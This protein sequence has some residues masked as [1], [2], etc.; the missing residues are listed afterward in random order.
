MFPREIPRPLPNRED[1]MTEDILDDTTKPEGVSRDSYDKRIHE[2]LRFLK[3]KSELFLSKEALKTYSPKFLKILENI[4]KH[5][6][7]HLIYSQFRT[8]EG[9]G[10]LKLILEYAG[11]VEFKI[12]KG[13]A[14]WRITHPKKLGKPAFVLYTGTESSEQKEIIRN[15]FN[16][17]WGKV[18]EN[19]VEQISNIAENNNNGEIIRVF[20]LTAAGA[21]GISLK[22]VRYVHITEP[23]WHPVRI[24]QVIGRAR[25]ICSHHS[26]PEEERFVTVFLYLMTFSEEM[27]KGD[28]LSIELRLHDTSRLD[29][30]TPLTSDE[31][32]YEISNIKKSINEQLLTAVKESSMDCLLYARIDG[33]EKLAC[34]TMGGATPNRFTY[35]PSISE[36]DDDK[37]ADLNLLKIKWKAKL[38]KIKSKGYAYRINDTDPDN[39]RH[40]LYDLESYKA[41]TAVLKGF[42]IMG[43]NN[44]PKKVKWL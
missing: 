5:E 24:E 30:T 28:K 17:D 31:A 13:R 40:E 11:F 10:I 16:S 3:K 41:G 29:K 27:I 4:E 21:E 18:P 14:G 37:A 6:G 35:P 38:F 32:L 42:L 44:K 36:T 43:E 22:N 7:L 9:I 2:A 25:R 34:F 8:L 33:K 15:I 20:M 26:L 39:I 23:Y 12:T 19:I 1:T